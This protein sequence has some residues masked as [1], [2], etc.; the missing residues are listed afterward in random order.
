MNLQ[1]LIPRSLVGQTV[2][3]L[4]AAVVLVHLGSMVAYRDSAFDAASAAHAEQL[5][6]RLATVSRSLAQLPV[7]GRDEAA[8]GLSSVGLS[9]RW[10]ERTEMG[11]MAVRD[12]DLVR[13]RDRLAMLLPGQRGDGVR[14]GYADRQPPGDAHAMLGSVG[15]PDGSFLS[16]RVPMIG[17][18]QP[19]LHA[20]VLSTSLMA[21]G[22]ALVAILLMRSIGRPLRGLARAADAIGRGPTIAVD[23]RG[24]E[25][26]RHVAV[27]FNG[28][29]ARIDRLV[30]DRTHA[31]AAVS[32]D[33]RTPITRLRLRAGFMADPELQ[34]AV[35]ADLDE[36]EAMIDSTLAYLRGDTEPEDP[37]RTDLASML[38][39]IVDDASDGGRSAAFEGPRHAFADVRPLAVKRAF[40]NLIDNA[41]T[42]GGCARVALSDEGA[43]LRVTVDDDGPGIAPE[44]VDRMFEPF[45]RMDA[46]RNRRT[47]GVGLGLAIVRQAVARE[48]GTVTLANRAGGGLRAEVTLSRREGCLAQEPRDGMAAGDAA[49]T[50]IHTLS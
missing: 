3:V 25:E 5:A 48:R 45:Q 42:H 14:L 1:A 24:P 28:M 11:A 33:L 31:L 15:L 20:A 2:A 17:D 32:H 35:D 43:L 8:H 36:M 7:A 40:A 9:L 10:S 13:L 38:S 18:E 41:L 22:V 19:G 23:E 21:G 12:P 26:V 39:T 16:F 46:S 47:G 6:E 30:A 37:R 44:N 29:Q 49:P 4:L 34:S 50:A 27:A